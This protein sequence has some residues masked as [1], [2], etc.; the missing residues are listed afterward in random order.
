MSPEEICTSLIFDAALAS[1]SVSDT[2]GGKA[3]KTG[4]KKTTDVAVTDNGV[5]VK[6]NWYSSVLETIRNRR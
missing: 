2:F 5:K 4:K 1:K 6:V 3:V